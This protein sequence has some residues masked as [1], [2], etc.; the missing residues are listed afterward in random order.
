MN[1][2]VEYQPSIHYIKLKCLHDSVTES[3]EVYANSGSQHINE[4]SDI[5]IT[6]DNC[7]ATKWQDESNWEVEQFGS[8]E[9]QEKA[10]ELR[11]QLR[12]DGIQP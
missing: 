10:D 12:E 7:N 6:C 11:Q 5:V 3:V 8:E 2:T 4:L 1:I 9:M